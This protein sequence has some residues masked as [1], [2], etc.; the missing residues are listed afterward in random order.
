MS[1]KEILKTAGFV[2]RTYSYGESDLIV[3][4][5][6]RDFGKIRISCSGKG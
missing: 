6:S 3:S 4:F 2:L 1:A 5:Y